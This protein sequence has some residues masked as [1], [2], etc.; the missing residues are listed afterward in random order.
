MIDDILDE[1]VVR[2]LSEEHNLN[3]SL[4]EHWHASLQ[5]ALDLYTQATTQNRHL[6]F[7]VHGYNNDMDEVIT[8]AYELEHR[9]K[10][11]VIV[12][13]WPS[14]GGGNISG[15]L[16]YLSDKNDARASATALDRF[17]EK[18]RFY[19]H[20]IIAG[21]QRTLITDANQ[22]YPNNR[23]RAQ[24]LVT[25]LIDERCSVT[26]NLL[27]HSMGNYLLKYALMPSGS[28]LR[29]LTFNNIALVAADTNNE[30][31]KN[32]VNQI[33]YGNGLYIVI[34]RNDYALAWSRRKPGAE[35]KA[36]L[37][38]T[39]GRLDS[40]KATY[41]NVTQVSSVGNSHTYFNGLPIRDSQELKTLFADIF[42]G[43]HPE[44]GDYLQH[45]PNINAFQLKESR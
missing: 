11:L 9:Y 15:T 12:F 36:R 39:L 29:N 30:E 34:N 41:I 44:D 23:T 2:R 18:V 43:R 35:Q 28:S 40:P 24:E 13:S 45:Q 31:H 1:E 3:L 25:K 33:D 19:H 21:I 26:L 32:W 38:N 4:R 16:S 20:L 10:A 14:N 17:V 5:V 8:T 7:Y 27:C 22:R 37:G 42:E 6:L